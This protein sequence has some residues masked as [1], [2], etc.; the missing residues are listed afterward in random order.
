MRGIHGERAEREPVTGVLG[1]RPPAG[2]RS[3]G[4]GKAENF[5]V[6]RR[7]KEIANLPF[8]CVLGSGYVR[9]AAG[10]AL[11]LNPPLMDR[12]TPLR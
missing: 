2:S 7:R 8:S 12:R 3:R 6:L 9:A 10:T 11:P 4:W 5:S 1:L